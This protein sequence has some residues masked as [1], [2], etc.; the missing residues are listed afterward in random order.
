MTPNNKKPWKNIETGSG[1]GWFINTIR[2]RI[3]QK[4]K[5]NNGE[6]TCIY[7]KIIVCLAP[8]PMHVYL[9]LETF[10]LFIYFIYLLYHVLHM[11]SILLNNFVIQWIVISFYKI[12]I[13]FNLAV[14]PDFMTVTFCKTNFKIICQV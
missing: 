13:L 3:K 14:L 12:Q 11:Y 6:T 8:D 7:I 9:T 4:L 1:G 10:C 2:L 5:P